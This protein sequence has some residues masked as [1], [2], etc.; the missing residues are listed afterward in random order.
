[1]RQSLKREIFNLAGAYDLGEKLSEVINGIILS[2][3]L[4][5]EDP[6]LSEMEFS[7]MLRTANKCGVLILEKYSLILP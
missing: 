2:V 4:C 5:F 1:M 6:H 3:A 7:D